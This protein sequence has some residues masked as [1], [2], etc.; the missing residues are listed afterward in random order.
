MSWLILF[1]RIKKAKNF[2]YKIEVVE[3]YIF[4]K[5]YGVFNN[6]VKDFYERKKNSIKSEKLIYH[7]INNTIIYYS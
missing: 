6:F 1:R 4:D 3:S 5:G 2:G 7:K